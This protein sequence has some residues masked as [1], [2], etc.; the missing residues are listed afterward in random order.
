MIPLLARLPL[1]V[2]HALGSVLGWAIYLL[3]SPY[4]ARLRAHLA[5]AGYADAAT[6]RAAIAEAG[7]MVA[8]APKLWLRPCAEVLA[9]VRRVEG[10]DAV[11]AARAAGKGVVF[12][13]PHYGCFEITAQAVGETGPLTVLYRPARNERLARMMQAGRARGNVTLAA[14]TLG[15]VR[16]LLAALKR[17]EAVGILPDQV[18]AVGEGE[19]VEFFGRPAYTMTLAGKLAARA[20]VAAFL[21]MGRRLARGAGYDVRITPLSPA[22]AGESPARRVNRA[23][24]EA[25]REHPAQYLWGYNRYKRPPGAPAP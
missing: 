21:V 25:I 20:D 15:G 23:L 7:R 17:R 10:L 12:L 13:T 5:Q 14:A 16:Q 2:L 19:W 22:R 9:L 8:E 11:A 1:R 18:P 24:E 6:R 4:R 3:S